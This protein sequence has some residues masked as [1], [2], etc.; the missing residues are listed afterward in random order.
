M[1]VWVTTV[2]DRIAFFTQTTS[3]KARNLERDTRALAIADEENAYRAAHVHGRVVET[4]TDA[5][6]WHDV[7]EPDGGQVHRRAVSLPARDD[8]PLPG[9]GRVGEGADAAL[10]SPGLSELL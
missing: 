1:P 10:P 3:S 2:G 8:D 9:R 6:I 5:A 4:R 7:T